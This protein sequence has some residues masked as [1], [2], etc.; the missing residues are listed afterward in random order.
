ML[1]DEIDEFERDLH[2]AYKSAID[3]EVPRIIREKK[4]AGAA[5]LLNAVAALVVAPWGIVTG[6]SD[7]LI[8][9]LEFAGYHELAG[10]TRDRIM[11][12]LGACLRLL[13]ERSFDERPVLLAFA[14]KLRERYAQK[15][16]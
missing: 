16:G 5:Q 7:I 8:S 15:L 11:Q 1:M 3:R 10:A 4:I 14:G 2:R 12:R 9:G 13:D 6:A